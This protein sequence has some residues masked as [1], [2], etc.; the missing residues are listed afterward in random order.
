MLQVHPPA[1]QAPRSPRAGRAAGSSPPVAG[2]PVLGRG[3]VCTKH[4]PG[5]SLGQ[6]PREPFAPRG[7]GSYPA[8]SFCEVAGDGGQRS[9]TPDK[10]PGRG[11]LVRGTDLALGACRR[12]GVRGRRARR[13]ERR[14]D[15]RH[16]G[17]P[18]SSRRAGR[19]PTHASHSHPKAGPRGEHWTGDSAESHTDLPEG[20]PCPE[21]EG[22]SEGTGQ[23]SGKGLA[24]GLWCEVTTGR[25]ASRQSWTGRAGTIRKG[26]GDRTS[27]K[28]G[29]TPSGGEAAC[30]SAESNAP[31]THEATARIKPWLGSAERWPSTWRPWVPPSAPRERE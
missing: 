25:E 7:S 20:G 24:Q 2:G 5:Q 29:P 22:S 18:P 8:P 13:A 23:A 12:R 1:H 14:G 21:A 4:R 3:Q 9:A 28:A 27:R 17:T 19:V 10:G 26:S 11:T 30:P 31:G 16:R 15:V 6:R